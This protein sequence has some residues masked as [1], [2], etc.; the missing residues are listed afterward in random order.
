MTQ[1]RRRMV[2]PDRLQFRVPADVREAVERGAFAER[3][4]AGEYLRRLVMAGLEA[5]GV[6][7]PPVEEGA[8]VG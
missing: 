1:T 6:A 3:C 4:G 2:Y 8:R 7:L 5:K